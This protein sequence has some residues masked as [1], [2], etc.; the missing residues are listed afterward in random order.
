MTWI[1]ALSLTEYPDGSECRAS[2][3]ALA[4]DGEVRAAVAGAGTTLSALSAVAV[5]AGSESLPHAVIKVT[6]P[7][8][9]SSDRP[10]DEYSE[11]FSV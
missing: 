5:S 3:S 4:L 9:A 1:P 8:A 2:R 10:T 11:Y 7:S 6:A